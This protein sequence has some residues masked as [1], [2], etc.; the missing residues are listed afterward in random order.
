MIERLAPFSVAFAI[1]ISMIIIPH[2]EPPEQAANRSPSLRSMV[3]R[4]LVAPLASVTDENQVTNDGPEGPAVEGRYLRPVARAKAEKPA[5]WPLAYAEIEAAYQPVA[6]LEAGRAEPSPAVSDTEE[7]PLSGEREGA[8]R[9]EAAE[10]PIF[11]RFQHSTEYSGLATYYH[12]SLEGWRMANGRPYDPSAMT[13]ASNRWPLGTELLVTYADN[14]IIVEI[15]D[16]GSFR[17]ALD[18][19]EAAFTALAGSTRPGVLRV[20]IQEAVDPEEED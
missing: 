3:K 19:S 13:A 20:T 10:N 2:L 16:R 14:S 12:P 7:S 8:E 17:H 1:G 9:S 18:L 11:V 5:R 6:F 15:T 4:N